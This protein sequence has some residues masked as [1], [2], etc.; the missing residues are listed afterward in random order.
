M[1]ILKIADFRKI[2]VLFAHPR[3]SSSIVQKAMLNAIGNIDHVTVHDL[4]AAYPNFLIDVKHEQE[5]LKAHDVIIMQHPFFW[6]SSPSIIKEWMDLVLQFGWAY[7]S[8][9]H[10]LAGKYLMTALSTGGGQE[11][12]AKNGSNR[13]EIDDFLKPFCQTAHLCEMIWL[14]P[15]TLYSGRTLTAPELA[16]Q[17]E[18]YRDL[19]IDLRDCRN[20]PLNSLNSSSEIPKPFTIR[21][22]A[23]ES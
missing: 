13:F 23:H 7:G 6:Y 2:L 8:S 9:G 18:R 11:A 16:F 5:L 1:S 17:T 21:G 22:E 10:Q 3:M 20:D 14:K 4:Y 12:Y 15:F 19:I